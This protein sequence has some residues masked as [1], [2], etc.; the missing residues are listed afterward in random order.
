MAL[1]FFM[2]IPGPAVAP[3]QFRIDLGE[4]RRVIVRAARPAPADA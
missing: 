4:G 1:V 3:R 2:T